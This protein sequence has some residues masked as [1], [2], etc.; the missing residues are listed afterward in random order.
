MRVYIVGNANVGKSLLFH[1]ITGLK[2][3]SSNYPG[4]TV[5]L[6]EGVRTIDGK[7]MTFYDLPGTYSLTGVSQDEHI[8]LDMLTEERPDKVIVLANAT[9]PLQ[10]LI[11]VLQLLELGYDVVLGL[12][13]MDRARNRFKIDVEGIGEELGIPVIPMVARTGEG[14][15]LLLNALVSG[16]R[17]AM[18]AQMTYSDDLEGAIED[19]EDKLRPMSL[20]FSSRGL[21]IKALEGNHYFLETLPPEIAEMARLLGRTT[22]DGESIGERIGKERQGHAARVVS[23][24]FEPIAHAESLSERISRW[25]LQPVTGTLIFISVLLGLFLLIVFIGGFIAV[26]VHDAYTTLFGP[27][28]QDLGELIGGKPGEAIS[29]A[30]YLSI[31]GIL[32]IVVPYVIPFFILLG[33]LEDSGYM[34]RMAVLVDRATSKLGINGKAIIPMMVGMGCSVPAIL[35]TRIMESK[36]ERL[37][38]AILIVMAIP[39]SAQTIII[40]GT[41][42]LYSGIEYAVFIYVFLLTLLVVVALVVRKLMKVRPTPLRMDLPEMTVPS[43]GNVLIKTYLRSKDFVVIAFPI[44]LAGSLVLQFLMVYGILDEL[45]EPLAPFTVGFLGLP[46]VTIVAFIFGIVRKE[47]TIQMLFVLFGTTN[48]ALYMTA[49]Q[50]LIFAIIMATYV[51]CLAVSVAIT[52]EFGLRSAAIIFTGTIIFSFLLG[53]LFNFLLTGT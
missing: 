8:A 39:C 30:I 7:E 27:L 11:L 10:S 19:V 32:L 53:G 21:A 4:T 6:T 13:F 16:K 45:V 49:D 50:F 29:S 44:L 1:R 33:V 46:A 23:A 5:D 2:V 47:M 26:L 9:V 3:I 12:N 14:V 42:G 35:G 51:P 18:P 52:R 17:R 25:T 28:F 34:P 41:V 38:L 37:A 20:G 31:E 15:D 48:L 24:R 40:L 43:A 36:G 22:G